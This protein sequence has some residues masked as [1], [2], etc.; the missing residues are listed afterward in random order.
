MSITVIRPPNLASVVKGEI[1]LKL[2][3]LGFSATM[4]CFVGIENKTFRPDDIPEPTYQQNPQKYCDPEQIKGYNMSA[5]LKWL[6]RRNRSAQMNNVI[7]WANE[8]ISTRAAKVDWIALEREP[9]IDGRMANRPNRPVK[10]KYGMFVC[11]HLFRNNLIYCL[12][13]LGPPWLFFA[14]DD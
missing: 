14:E 10:L 12:P 7:F 13:P 2:N 8:Q 3:L 4:N 6:A 9:T 1:L 5:S 11:H